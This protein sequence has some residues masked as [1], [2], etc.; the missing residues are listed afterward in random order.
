MVLKSVFG[1][2]ICVSLLGGG[3]ALADAYKPDEFLSLDLKKAVLSPKLI[4]PPAQFEQVPVAAKAD[5]E[6]K[7][8][9][10]IQVTHRRVA[11]RHGIVHA[12]APAVHAAAPRPAHI[13]RTKLVRRHSNPLD[14][15]ASDTQIQ[16]WPCKSGGICNWQR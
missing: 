10:E 7:A 12:P 13:A 4:G 1:A 2:I 15:Q 16:V 11:K 9:P 6:V 8:E 3:A 5:P 14:A